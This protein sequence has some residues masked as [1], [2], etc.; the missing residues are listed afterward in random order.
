MSF[1]CKIC[2]SVKHASFGAI[3]N[4]T[5]HL[6][7]HPDYVSKWLNPFEKQTLKGIKV[8]DDN[9]FNL[10]RAIISA[11]LPLAILENEDFARFLNMELN[12]IKTFRNSTLP[13]VYDLMIQAIEKKLDHAKTMALITDIWSNKILA[14]FLA[15]GVLILNEYHRQELFVIGMESMEGNHTS[16]AIKGVL[17]DIINR[18]S[19]NKRLAKGNY[20]KKSLW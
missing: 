7:T 5:S 13:R 14:D 8:I 9:T 2:G 4:L 18:Y 20:L 16:E 6:I 19:F 15:L 3:Q 10:V 11:N 12:S 1:K 17:E